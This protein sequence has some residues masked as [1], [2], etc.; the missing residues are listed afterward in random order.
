MDIFL[1]GGDVN[2]TLVQ[3]VGL[4]FIWVAIALMVALSSRLIPKWVMKISV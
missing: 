2:E 1:M 3:S 4:R